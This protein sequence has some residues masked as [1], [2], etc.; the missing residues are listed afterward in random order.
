MQIPSRY[1]AK[2]GVMGFLLPFIHQFNF[3]EI[4]QPLIYYSAGFPDSFPLHYFF[5][6][7]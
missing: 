6:K 1:P 2:A 7:T 3:N 5:Y 4:I